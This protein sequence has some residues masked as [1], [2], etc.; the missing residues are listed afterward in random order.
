MLNKQLSTSISAEILYTID[1]DYTDL[2]KFKLLISM[3]TLF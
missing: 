2:Y 1:T 3:L